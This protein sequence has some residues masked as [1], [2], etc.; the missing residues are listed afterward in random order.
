MADEHEVSR[1]DNY[2]GLNVGGKIFKTSR[3]TLL[4]IPGSFFSSLL[5]GSVPSAK[6]DQGNFLI[7]QDGKI[8]RHVLNFLRYGKLVLPEGFGEYSLLE[9]QADFFQLEKL[10]EYIERHVSMMSVGL[11]FPDGKIFYTTKDILLKEEK[12]FFTKMLSGE[13]VVPRDFQGIY[14]LKR[15]DSKVFHHIINYLEKGVIFD[16]LN[17]NELDSLEKEAKHFGLHLFADHLKSVRFMISRR[18]DE[19]LHIHFYYCVNSPC[20]VYKTLHGG[21]DRDLT[22]YGSCADKPDKTRNLLHNRSTVYKGMESGVVDM[23]IINSTK[24]AS[25]GDV[26]SYLEEKGGPNRI[27]SKPKQSHLSQGC[28]RLEV[29]PNPNINFYPRQYHKT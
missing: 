23:E 14:I 5:E 10:S 19:G 29:L 26:M 2:V 11:M 1:Q 21:Y 13:A 22:Y 16:P 15:G 27:P 20:V 3:S 12:S 18:R 9:C 25:L 7:D 24:P 6:D 17:E 28:I 8:F 4:C